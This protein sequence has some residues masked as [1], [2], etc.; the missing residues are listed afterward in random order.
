MHWNSFRFCIGPVPDKW[1]DIADEAGLL[2]QNEF[3]IWTGRNRYHNE[4]STSEMIT[5]YKEWLRDN[6]NHPSVAVWD[7][8]NETLSD[9]FRAKIIPAVRPLD[10]SNRPWENG[11]NLPVG[12][13][14]PV[15]D[16]P[17][18][19]S[20]IASGR[21][22]EF[23]MTDLERMT[24]AKSANSAH[25]TGHP[26]ILNEYG[27][28]WLNRDGAPTVLTSKVYEK[29]LGP[30]ATPAERLQLDAYLLAGL[31]EF[32]RAHR[33]FAGVLHFVFL[34]SSYPGAFTS[35]H[36]QDVKA[37]KLE[38]HFQDYVGEAFKPLGVYIN[39]WQPTLKAGSTH[40][41]AV[42]MVNDY[43]HPVEGKLVLS[44][45]RKGASHETG[46]TLN[47]LGQQT[48]ELELQAPDS[49]GQYLLKAAAYPKDGSS[50]TL[51]RRRV[52]I[53]R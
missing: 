13:D 39:F 15:E 33:N 42:M 20:S 23:K 41:F 17:Y 32:W 29:L 43:D 46:F 18:L 7:A 47:A 16:H 25:P 4:W 30:N 19:F 8:N 21:T 26:V 40:R 31:T 37:L 22:P 27:W 5:E 28:L 24:G 49:P 38:P 14:D 3:F 48:Y 53:S 50:P 1:L 36:F 9:V 44:F 45:E 12:P 35:D 34:T 51:S 6:W 10:L 2:I 52:S 11:Y